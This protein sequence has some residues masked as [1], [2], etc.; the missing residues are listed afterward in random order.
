M[1]EH[2]STA[3]IHADITRVYTNDGPQ[4]HAALGRLWREIYEAGKREGAPGW[5]YLAAALLAGDHE[6]RAE[7][8]A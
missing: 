5:A 2:R 3:D 6:A 4:D 8:G 1:T 7:R